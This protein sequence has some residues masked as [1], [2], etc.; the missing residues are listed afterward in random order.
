MDRQIVA[1]LLPYIKAEYGAS[2]AELGFMISIV[3]YSMVIFVIPAGYLVDRWSRKKMLTVMALIWS[4]A[5]AACGMAGTFWHLVMARFFIGTGEG[6]YNPAGQTLLSASFP[7]RLRASVCAAIP[8]SVWLG[9]PLGL[10][11]GAYI[12]EH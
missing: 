3:N 2:D 8:A 4:F 9:A 11:I 1:A 12:A 5:T 7:K 6:G 10:W